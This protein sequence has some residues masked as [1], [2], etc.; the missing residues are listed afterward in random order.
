[1][2]CG[3]P[4]YAVI[5]AQKNRFVHTYF[6]F[7][8]DIFE[9]F[10]D[11][12]T[13]KHVFSKLFPLFPYTFCV[14]SRVLMCL[15]SR[16]A[17]SQ[18]CPHRRAVQN[19]GF[20]AQNDRTAEPSRAARTAAKTPVHPPPHTQTSA[21]ASIGTARLARRASMSEKHFSE[22]F[23]RYTGMHLSRFV[24]SV[25]AAYAAELLRSDAGMTVPE[26]A[27]RSGFGSSSGFYKAFETVF[28]M[29]PTKY[30]LSGGNREA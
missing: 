6:L 17:L 21:R 27:M 30:A 11:F 26:A 5:V 28:G 12:Y 22:R 3:F 9:F 29:P 25:R 8:I 20:F 14:R 10:R 2:F 19:I 24:N 13:K 23:F 16:T 4:L 18:K 15:Q 7:F 1:M